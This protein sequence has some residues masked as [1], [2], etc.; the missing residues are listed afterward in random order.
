M[1]RSSHTAAN[2]PIG[3]RA[4]NKALVKVT[5]HDSPGFSLAEIMIA[6]MLFGIM[7]TAF[8]ASTSFAHKVAQS[9][10]YE[11]TAL[12][13]AT[14]YIEQVKSI[15]YETLA[16]CILDNSTPIPTMINQGTDDPLYIGKYTSKT[17][18][19]RMD[20]K[21]SVLQTM[22]LEVRPELSNIFSATGEKL[23]TIEIHYRWTEP[24][25]SRQREN[26]IRTARSYVPTF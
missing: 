25:S 7:A 21:G 4:G 15:E 19:I 13:V 8:M 2:G 23:L 6:L 11:S 16:A 3:S 9:S 18:P 14:G 26:C 12:T 17:V 22:K 5:L 1:D 24:G 10:I 20:D